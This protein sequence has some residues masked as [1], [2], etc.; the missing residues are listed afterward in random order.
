MPD[1]QGHAN[2]RKPEKAVLASGDYYPPLVSIILPV[3]NCERYITA[4]IE[5][6]LSQ[7]YRPI[8]GIVINDGSTDATSGCLA[9]F[10]SEIQIYSQENMGLSYSLNQG[11]AH[12]SGEY[13]GFL[14][15]DDLWLPHKLARQVEY[16]DQNPEVSMVFGHIQQFISPELDER[17]KQTLICSQSPEP[18][19]VKITMLA[20]RQ[21]F[22]KVGL[23]N[24]AIRVGD[25]VDWYLRVKDAGL[26]VH[27]LAE[28]VAMRRLHKS[29]STPRDGE[30]HQELCAYPQSWDRSTKSQIRG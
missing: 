25:F 30:F 26:E 9:A 18:G 6:I 20:R 21:V 10:S 7:T 29:H 28:V 23:F 19:Y 24:S 16:L 15:A 3:Y 22:D 14:D 12:A 8:E 11:L 17:A 2:S 4:A 27:M 1:T 13:I 5:S